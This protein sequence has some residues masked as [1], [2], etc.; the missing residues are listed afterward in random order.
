LAVVSDSYDIYHACDAI[1]GGELKQAVIDSGA[2]VVIRPDS[3]NPEEVVLKVAQILSQRFGYTLNSKGYKV[4]NHVRI[5]QGDGIN[6]NSLKLCLSNLYHNGFAA[7]NIAFGM[8]G[9]LL[10]QVNRDTQQFAMKCSAMQ[11]DGQWREVY[12]D[13]VGD[14]AKRSKRGQL[15]V[16]SHDDNNAALPNFTTVQKTAGEAVAGDLLLPVYENGKLLRNCTLD[17]VRSRA[18]QGLGLLMATLPL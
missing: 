5:I 10:Q 4:I 13:P 6:L 9:G 17:Q 7:D 15:A 2:T 12:K 18:A 11:V 3:G 1:W 14:A 16:L 8:G